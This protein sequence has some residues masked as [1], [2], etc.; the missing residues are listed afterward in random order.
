VTTVDVFAETFAWNYRYPQAL[1]NYK[2]PV[3]L[4][5][6]RLMV[7]FGDQVVCKLRSRDVIHSMFIPHMRVKQDTVP[8]L[9]QGL[10]FEPA[11][12][13]VIEIDPQTKKGVKRHWVSEP[14]AFDEGGPEVMLDGKPVKLWEKRIAVDTYVESEAGLSPGYGEQPDGTYDVIKT[15]A[16]VKKKVNVL[17]RGK[18]YEKQ[19]WDSC[20]YAVGIFE[21]ACA[22]LCGLGHYK[23]KSTLAVLPRPAYQRWIQDEVKDLNENGDVRPPPPIWKLWKE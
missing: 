18:V 21:V 14:R 12:I 4:T 16:G 5:V 11:R 10:W 22:E 13:W 1:H 23:M 9:R 7:P 6:G 15:P 3:E 17:H 20:E 19:E 8:G 2:A